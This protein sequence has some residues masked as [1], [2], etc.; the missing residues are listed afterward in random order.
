MGAG[1]AR[2]RRTCAAAGQAIALAIAGVVLA[3]LTFGLGLATIVIEL[4]A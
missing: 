3:G 4:A 2:W 1:H